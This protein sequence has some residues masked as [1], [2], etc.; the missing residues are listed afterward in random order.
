[1]TIGAQW[2]IDAAEW[3]ERDRELTGWRAE[4]RE[5]HERR[6]T[7]AAGR[8]DGVG[9]TWHR[10]RAD[11]LSR[12][13]TARVEGCDRER[14]VWG[15]CAGCG[16]VHTRP[17]GCGQ[18]HWCEGCARR[19]ARQVRRR[20]IVGLADAARAERGRGRRRARPVMLTL[21]V[22][23]SGSP[24][25]DRAVIVRGWAR[26]RAWLAARGTPLR[27][28]AGA[29]EVADRGGAAHV[30][31]HVVALAPW[32]PVRELA[33]EWVR[34]TDGAAEAQGLDLSPCSIER[35]A[36]Y[37]AKYAAKGADPRRISRETWLAWVQLSRGKRSFCSS[38]GLTRARESSR[39][40]C[41]AARGAIWGAI[42]TRPIGDGGV[43]DARVE[44]RAHTSTALG[45]WPAVPALDT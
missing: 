35:G 38:R 16:Q 1:M 8:G 45:C 22:R 37:A 11:A 30:H 20:I 23:H 26:L 19:R 43:F 6:A 18:T 31:L 33:A 32:V 12:C 7:A 24:A 39:P 14:E 25:D 36:T 34:A 4:L 29:W 21:T 3:W 40:P 13:W 44:V 28:Y 2:E 10:Q 41:C 15:W 17:V 9:A 27:A 5:R 42:G